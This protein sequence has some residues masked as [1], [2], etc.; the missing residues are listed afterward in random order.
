M[1]QTLTAD[2]ALIDRATEDLNRVREEI[3]KVIVGQ[4]DVI[5][6]VLMCLHGRGSCVA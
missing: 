1:A 2:A 4:T 5:D 6:G 3:G